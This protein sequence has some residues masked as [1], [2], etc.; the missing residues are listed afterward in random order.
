MSYR[1]VSTTIILGVFS[2]MVGWQTVYAQSGSTADWFGRDAMRK[3]G[4]AGSAQARAAREEWERDRALQLK[5]FDEAY[6]KMLSQRERLRTQLTERSVD[7]Q[8]S[9][10]LSAEK[11]ASIRARLRTLGLE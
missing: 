11:Q 7:Q 6:Q 5:T 3:A 4:K 1:T 2:A 9:T 8:G 10:G